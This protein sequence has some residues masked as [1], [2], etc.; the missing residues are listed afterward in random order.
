[1][2]LHHF[3]FGLIC[4]V[5]GGLLAVHQGLETYQVGY[6]VG[7]LLQ[8][9][10]RLREAEHRLEVALGALQRPDRL[11]ERAARMKIPL[12]SPEDARSLNG[13]EGEEP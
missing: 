12:V 2:K 1:M 4:F 5:I 6:R 10:T 9:R 11:R 13:P 8:Q 3:A 7:S